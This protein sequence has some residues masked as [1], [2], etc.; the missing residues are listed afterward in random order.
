[1][2]STS[3]TSWT[4]EPNQHVGRSSANKWGQA[5]MCQV[6]HIVDHSGGKLRFNTPVGWLPG[7]A[8]QERCV[9]V[10]NAWGA[11]VTEICS[12]HRPAADSNEVKMNVLMYVAVWSIALIVGWSLGDCMESLILFCE[13]ITGKST[14]FS[15]TQCIY[16][17][18]T[19]SLEKDIQPTTIKDRLFLLKYCPPLVKVVFAVSAKWE[20]ILHIIV[21]LWKIKFLDVPVTGAFS[22][23]W[24]VYLKIKLTSLSFKLFWTKTTSYMLPRKAATKRRW[25][26]R[27]RF[28]PF[29]GA[30]VGV[31]E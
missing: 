28:K 26:Q 31:N 8:R 1:M 2:G 11:C 16:M 7:Q 18:S 12:R 6:T 21:T 29:G 4:V 9:R 22:S 14:Q 17:L 20:L 3:V 19:L 24:A 13:H 15:M 25:A 5:A 23:L 10:T 30:V 27:Q